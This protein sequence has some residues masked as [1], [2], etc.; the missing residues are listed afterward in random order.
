MKLGILIMTLIFTISSI[1]VAQQWEDYD[2]NTET[3]IKGK[4]VEVLQRPN[5][6]MVLGVLKG[7]K[8]Y[9]ILTAP[10]WYYDQEKI[11]LTIGDEIVVHGSKYFSRRGELFLI[12]RSIHNLSNGKIYSFREEHHMKPKWRGRGRDRKH[13]N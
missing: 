8:V 4:I 13:E 9:Y 7:G 11:S 10:K 1:A 12:A 3:A 2:P 6:P 5:G